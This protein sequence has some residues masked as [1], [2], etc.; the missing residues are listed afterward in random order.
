MALYPKVSVPLLIACAFMLTS[1]SWA[2]VSHADPVQVKPPL[3]RTIDPPSPEATASDLESRADELHAQKLYF[4]AID[5]YRAV[6]GKIGVGEGQAKIYNKICRTQLVMTRWR[7]GQRSCQQAIKA[8]RKMP[9]PYNNLGV[10]YYEEKRYGAA[11]K[12]YH[13]AIEL[14][15]SSASFYSNLG[16]ALFAK[17][18]FDKS[19][20]AYQHA[21]EL[22]PDVF[23]RSSRQGVQA[24]VPR[25]EDRALYDYTVAKLYAKMGFSDRSLEYLRKAMEEGYKNFKNVYKDQEFAELRKDKRFTQLMALKTPGLPE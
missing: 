8:D 20:Q 3:L 23:E 1:G 4:D 14:D 25:P 9:D 11:I 17:K 12:Q 21:L 6:L 13:K 22:D 10:A 2:Q 7:D 16:A 19:A 15:D 24:Q 18:D 5:Y